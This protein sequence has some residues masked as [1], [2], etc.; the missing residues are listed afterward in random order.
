MATRATLCQKFNAGE[1]RSYVATTFSLQTMADQYAELY[2]ELL[3]TGL[4]APDTLAAGE[5]TAA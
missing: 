4:N 3:D 2:S 1:V 5:P